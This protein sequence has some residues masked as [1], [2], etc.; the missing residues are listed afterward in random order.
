MGRKIE[1]N[2]QWLYSWLAQGK[3]NPWIREAWDPPFDEN[4]FWVCDDVNELKEKL[5]HGNWSLGSAFVVNDICLINQDDG[6]DEWLTIKGLVC[7]ESLSGGAMIENGTFDE[8]WEA[9]QVATDKELIDLTYM[10]REENMS[11]VVVARSAS[12]A[13]NAIRGE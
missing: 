1:P 5:I 13:V 6:G 7:F 2:H 11:G 9:I 4:S 12:D 3:A 10:R 8:F